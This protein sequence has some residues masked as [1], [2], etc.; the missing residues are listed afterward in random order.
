M[1]ASV[2]H[3][4]ADWLDDLGLGE[5]LE[6][7][8]L[9]HY[10]RDESGEP[11]WTDPA[12]GEA[13]TEEQ[14]EALDVLLHQ[15]GDEPG[16][17]VPIE[18]VRLRRQARVRAEL[19]ASEWFTYETLADLR[20][21]SV[22]ATRFAVHKAADRHQ[23][24][25]V[26]LEGR[27]IVPAFQLDAGGEVREELGAVLEP[28]LAARM[29]PWNVWAWLTQPAGLLGGAVPAEAVRDPEEVDIVRHAAVRLA[30]RVAEL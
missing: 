22:N 9:P 6:K 7:A 23:L 5:F 12:T 1:T 3:R 11:R 17:A 19:V 25:L 18:L 26:A 15:E 20:G 16:H 27:T 2:S 29:N 4:L 30:E 24:L 14:L 21:A 10:R 13:M 8:G 28:L